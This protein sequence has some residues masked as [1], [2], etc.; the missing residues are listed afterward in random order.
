MALLFCIF[1]Q[2]LLA[3]LDCQRAKKQTGA[4]ESPV[5]S[6]TSWPGNTKAKAGKN[7]RPGVPCHELLTQSHLWDDYGPLRDAFSFFFSLFNYS[8]TLCNLSI[9][10]LP[11][12]NPKCLRGH[13][14][15]I[16][17][18]PASLSSQ[19]QKRRI[20]NRP[21]AFYSCH[22]SQGDFKDLKSV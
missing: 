19:H 15:S 1:T 3:G 11:E 7:E 6:G 12:T 5:L 8:F 10:L 13:Q 21:F 20:Y 17:P 4:W 18:Q 22:P 14:N 9:C 2:Q 16:F